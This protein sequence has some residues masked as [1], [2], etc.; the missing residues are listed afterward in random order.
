MPAFE[1]RQNTNFEDN[2]IYSRRNN[3]VNKHLSILEL[4]LSSWDLN[5]SNH[6]IVFRPIFLWLW[7]W[8]KFTY[9]YTKHKNMNTLLQMPS[10][11]CF[12]FC[13]SFLAIHY[14]KSSPQGSLNMFYFVPWLSSSSPRNH[15][16]TC[17]T[18]RK[19]VIPLP[20]LQSHTGLLPSIR[21]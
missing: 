13:L 5:F 12:K 16:C 2:S 17:T 6:I 11:L 19:S 20:V 8:Q 3:Q 10:K 21:L 14:P 18:K 1:K 4:V 15:P 9:V 7:H